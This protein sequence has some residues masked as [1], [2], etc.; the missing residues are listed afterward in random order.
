MEP[1]NLLVIMSDEHSVKASGCYGHPIVKTPN[2]DR[3]SASGARFTNAY[4]NCPICTPARAG[5]ATGRFIHEIG[6]WDNAHPYTGD[7]PGWGRRL[8]AN[9]NPVISIGKLHYRNETDPTGFDR[10][11]VPMHARNGVGSLPGSVRDPLPVQGAKAL[12]AEIGPGETSYSNYDLD[13]TEKACHWIENEAAKE[14]D[15]PWMTFVSLVSPHF[16]LKA[17]QA[18]FD[19][20]SP[21]RMPLPKAHAE[22]GRPTHPWIDAFRRCIDSDDYFDDEKRRIAIASYF[23]LCSFLDHNIGRLLESFEKAGLS[24][25]TRIIYVSD[26]GENLGARGTWGKGTMYEE[27]AAIPLVM[28]GP[29]VPAGKEVSTPV[30]LVDFYQTI[31]EAVGVEPNEQDAG[32]PGSSLYGIASGPADPGRAVFSEYHAAGAETAAYMLR[33]DKFKY[34]HYV[35]FPPELF[36]LEADPEEQNDLA[37]SPVYREILGEMEAALRE[38]VD[39][40]GVDRMAKR[41]QAALIERHGGREAVATKSPTGATPTPG[42][43]AADGY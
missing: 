42:N 33:R 24:E 15:K 27:S 35:N 3:L 43:Y 32:L 36:D 39:P 23:G 8:Q 29:G 5:F 18:F 28:S 21:D 4:T 25:S 2:I 38:I 10:Q 17:P 19:M 7:A 30:S 14:A 6:N 1:K 41:D 34:I 26:H 31:L 12:A 37:P 40:E 11:V 16:P 20:Y 9:G 22:D 13:I